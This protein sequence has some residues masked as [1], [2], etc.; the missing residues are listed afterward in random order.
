MTGNSPNYSK[1]FTKFLHR[2]YHAYHPTLIAKCQFVFVAHLDDWTG[3]SPIGYWNSSELDDITSTAQFGNMYDI[4]D[5]KYNPGSFFCDLKNMN[6]YDLICSSLQAKSQWREKGCGM[7]LL[8]TKS[9][10]H[11]KMLQKKY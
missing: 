4:Y 9:D 11:Q 2:Y 6:M 3:G 8:T 1:Y 5:I 7:L 10:R